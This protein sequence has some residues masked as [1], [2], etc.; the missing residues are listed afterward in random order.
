MAR[1]KHPVAPRIAVPDLAPRLDPAVLAPG[2][3]LLGA[4]V[5]GSRGDINAANAHISESALHNLDVARFDLSRARL[6]DVDVSELRAVTVDA[7]ES[8]WQSTR[9]VG[10]RI[11]TLDLSRSTLSAV[12]F[13]GIRIDYLTLAG[14]EASDL[15]FADCIIGSMD[16]PQASLKRVAFANSRVTDV[17]NRGWR[18]EHVDLRGLEAVHFMDMPALRGTTLSERQATALGRDFAVAA[19]VDVRD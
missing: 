17:D 6:S 19:G 9:I 2:V 10:G 15:L 18:V 5:E 11:A 7:P 13:R 1:P 12:E 16:A 8:R 3:D 14:A 4:L